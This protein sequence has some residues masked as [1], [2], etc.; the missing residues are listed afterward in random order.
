MGGGKWLFSE[1]VG[2][3]PTNVQLMDNCL[4]GGTSLIMN[5]QKKRVKFTLLGHAFNEKDFWPQPNEGDYWPLSLNEAG[6]SMRKRE[7]R[8]RRERGTETQGSKKNSAHLTLY[9]VRYNH[10]LRYSYNTYHLARG[11]RSLYR[12]QEVF[13][14]K[15]NHHKLTVVPQTTTG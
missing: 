9:C 4:M 13:T 5:E 6:G 3:P 10:L 1:G 11:S 15:K 7:T 12:K 8:R 2:G 14:G